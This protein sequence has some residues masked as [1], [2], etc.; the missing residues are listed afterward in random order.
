MI[1][2][3]LQDF[4]WKYVAQATSEEPVEDE[5]DWPTTASQLTLPFLLDDDVSDLPYIYIYCMQALYKI[6]FSNLCGIP[7]L[8]ARNGPNRGRSSLVRARSPHASSTRPRSRSAQLTDVF[9]EWLSTA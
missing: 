4:F 2:M 8:Q 3:V 5:K 9:I 1:S 7:N 6:T